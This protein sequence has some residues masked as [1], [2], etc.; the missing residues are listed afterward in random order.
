[1]AQFPF[2]D[3]GVGLV[4]KYGPG[5]EEGSMGGQEAKR[6]VAASVGSRR[7]REA[8]GFIL[9]LIN[10]GLPPV[11]FRR[12]IARAVVRWPEEEAGRV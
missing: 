3:P 12:F 1:M 5:T 11:R 4:A 8:Q 2:V 9:Y 6:Y 10:A 7:S